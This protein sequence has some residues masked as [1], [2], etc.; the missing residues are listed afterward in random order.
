[1][2]LLDI[3]HVDFN[4]NIGFAKK[5]DREK[6]FIKTLIK[7]L[8]RIKIDWEQFN[9]NRQANFFQDFNSFF[10]NYRQDLLDVLMGIK[11]HIP[12]DAWNSLKD[13][14]SKMQDAQNIS[15]GDFS[16]VPST[17][18]ENNMRHAVESSTRKEMRYAGEKIAEQCS[19][20]IK[21]LEEKV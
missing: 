18:G 12:E 1:M 5:E 15:R 20:L 14:A 2:G 19:E 4:I 16:N 9:A 7:I 6:A 3:F 17:M 21:N 11:E 13:L 8:N 10:Y